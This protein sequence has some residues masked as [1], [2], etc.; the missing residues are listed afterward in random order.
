M[1]IKAIIIEGVAGDIEITRTS[2]GA[3]VTQDHRVLAE[4][5]RHED[6]DARYAKAAEVAIAVYGKGRHGRAAATNS[7]VCD[8]LNEIERLAGC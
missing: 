1:N 6:R 8:V 5:G 2:S 7:M 4:I 3:Q